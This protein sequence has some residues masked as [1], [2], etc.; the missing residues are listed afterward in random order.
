MQKSEHLARLTGVRAIAALFVV[1]LHYRGDLETFLPVTKL[2]D[3][4]FSSGDLGVD[5]FFM[6]S[7]FVLMLNHEKTFPRFDRHKYL[8]FLWTR[9][10]RIYPAH[11]FTL[12]TVTALVLCARYLHQPVRH[13]EWYTASAWLQNVFLIQAWTGIAHTM[14]WNFPAWSISSEWFAYLG[15][16]LLVPAFTR[17]KR[18]AIGCCVVLLPYVIVCVMHGDKPVV[19]LALLR[20]SCEFVAG[21][22]LYLAF[23]RALRI[24][25]NTA[26]WAALIVAFLWAA[27]TYGVTREFVLPAFAA[28]LLRLAGN[29]GG[30]L[31]GKVA[32]FWGEASYAL[33]LTHGICE[34][35]LER[36]IK[37]SDFA[38]ASL[39]MRCAAAAGYVVVIAAA[40][41]VTHLFVERP[42]RAWMRGLSRDQ[43]QSS[44]ANSPSP[45]VAVVRT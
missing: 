38:A 4:L 10:A 33:Y 20:V 3:T 26:L 17:M 11:L 5:L 35:V 23:D 31:S 41:I 14:S 1:F 24:P 18:P 22:M 32:V 37:P 40:A 7:G 6:L 16:P 27:H 29:P 15:F 9:L 8:K 34:E 44:V 25:G 30:F 42:A 39:L 28:L 13:S 12:L 2:C 19:P 43:V 21:C 45:R 36:A